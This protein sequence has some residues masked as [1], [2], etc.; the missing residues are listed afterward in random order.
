MQSLD[1][2]ASFTSAIWQLSQIYEKRGKPAHARELLLRGLKQEPRAEWAREK[3]ARLETVLAASLLEEA[4]RLMAAGDFDKA[5]PK[6]SLYLG[7]RPHDPT[8]L[9]R[10]GRC[11]LGLGNLDRARE[12]VSQA[13]ERDP[14]DPAARRLLDEIDA[15]IDRVSVESAVTEARRIL[16][17]YTEERREEAEA[18]L[19]VV[20]DRDPGN[21]WATA[22]LGEL[23]ELEKRA[24]EPPAVDIERIGRKSLE[25]VETLREPIA[26]AGAFLMR[27]LPYLVAGIVCVLLVIDIRKR[28][29][30]RSYPLEGSLSVIPILD[31]VSMLNGNLKT[32]R[33]VVRTGDAAGEV[34]LE[35]GEIV[36]ARWRNIDG[37]DAFYRIMSRKGGSFRF[38]NHLPNVRHSIS[39][40][41]S[42]L[43]LSMKAG[44]ETTPAPEPKRPRRRVKLFS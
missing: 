16:A 5:I 13:R 24:A 19:R 22:K 7:M 35:R 40:P 44:G 32:G 8:P 23:A 2:D 36:H 42:L 29:A 14:T 15:R 38:L 33:L 9:V 25:R 1:Q 18:A 21:G 34:F 43:L 26:G 28:T 11:H 37:K 31:I 3:L 39:E 20:L 17:D 4:D 30:R 10:L 12:Y 41:L 6:L 27:F